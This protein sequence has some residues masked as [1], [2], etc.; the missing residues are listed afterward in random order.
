MLLVCLESSC[1]KLTMNL[2]DGGIDWSNIIHPEFKL[3]DDRIKSF[4]EKYWPSFN[5]LN[6]NVLAK[7]GFSILDRVILLFVHIVD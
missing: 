5:N 4:S 7:A 6:A 3:L 2:L 1:C